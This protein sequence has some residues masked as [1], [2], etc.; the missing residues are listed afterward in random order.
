MSHVT[1]KFHFFELT[2]KNSRGHAIVQFLGGRKTAAKDKRNYGNVEPFAR[3]D[4]Q[5]ATRRDRFCA[6]GQKPSLNDLAALVAKKE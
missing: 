4:F 1:L 2:N 6:A 5:G 3:R